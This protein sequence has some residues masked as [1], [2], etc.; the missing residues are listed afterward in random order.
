MP[1]RKG[2]EKSTATSGGEEPTTSRQQVS[3]RKSNLHQSPLARSRLDF[4]N[5]FGC[6]LLRTNQVLT[7][8]NVSNV[9][10]GARN[11]EDII[12]TAATPIASSSRASPSP[13]PGT[14]PA[15]MTNT[16]RKEGETESL[17]E[18]QEERARKRRKQDAERKRRQRALAT[19]DVSSNRIES[20]IECACLA[21]QASLYH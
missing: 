5:S 19:E 4:T 14:S 18:E 6:S 2:A 16:S 20:R 7:P 12:D 21:C 17:S 3:A 8:Q 1:F 13:V 9:R 15:K 10:D 11:P